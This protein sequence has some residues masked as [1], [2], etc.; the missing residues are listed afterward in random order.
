MNEE[1]MEEEKEEKVKTRY[2]IDFG[3]EKEIQIKMKN[4]L[5]ELNEKK[6]GVEI[7]IKN[8]LLDSILNIAK[9]EKQR[10]IESSYS[11]MDKVKI[12]LEEFNKSNNTNLELG[13]YLVKKLK[14]KK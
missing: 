8:I 7:T 4:L 1:S 12:E 3:K 6:Y 11:D 2:M 5:N 10:I 13:E 9:R 14:I